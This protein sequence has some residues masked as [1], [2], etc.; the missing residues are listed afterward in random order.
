MAINIKTWALIV[1]GLMA[2]QMLVVYLI[3]RANRDIFG[4][5]PASAYGQAVA[6]LAEKRPLAGAV[7]RIC[8]GLCIVEVIGLALIKY[9]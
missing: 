7:V 5:R 2:L 3:S 1:V 4:N 6:E 8:Y 9:A